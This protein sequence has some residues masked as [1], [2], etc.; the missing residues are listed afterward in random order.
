M[1]VSAI[2]VGKLA[3]RIWSGEGCSPGPVGG[4]RVKLRRHRKVRRLCLWF[5]ADQVEVASRPR[6]RARRTAG[7]SG[8]RRA[9][10][11]WSCGMNGPVSCR[12]RRSGDAEEPAATFEVVSGGSDAA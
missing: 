5:V 10:A 2:R 7:S 9:T 4:Q 3:E 8:G 6:S 12:C 11:S 1:L